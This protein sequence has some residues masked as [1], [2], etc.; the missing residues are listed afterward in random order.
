[1]IY[2]KLKS[3]AYGE[4]KNILDGGCNGLGDYNA[5]KIKK[6]NKKIC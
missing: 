3:A 1:M 6:I 4:G 2:N 5:N